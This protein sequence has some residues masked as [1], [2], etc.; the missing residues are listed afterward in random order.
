MTVK[1]S[2]LSYIYQLFNNFGNGLLSESVAV[3]NGAHLGL[4]TR[5]GNFMKQFHSQAEREEQQ[6]VT[7]YKLSFTS[8]SLSDAI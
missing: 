1:L 4:N 8:I 2:L 7:E 3:L 5:L 6:K